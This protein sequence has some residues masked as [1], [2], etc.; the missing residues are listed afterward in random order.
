MRKSLSILC[1]QLFVAGAVVSDVETGH[2]IQ[3]KKKKDLLLVMPGACLHG[4][5]KLSWGRGQNALISSC[6]GIAWVIN[7][8]V[9]IR[10][11]RYHC[12]LTVRAAWVLQLLGYQHCLDIN[13]G[14]LSN[15]VLSW[16]PRKTTGAVITPSSIFNLTFIPLFFLLSFLFFF[17]SSP[18][19]SR[20][21]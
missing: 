13:S 11:P 18:L 17:L 1:R 21:P 19:P 3:K 7:I 4:D 2:H 5:S 12:C 10:R 15:L 20:L 6:A 9:S 16:S 14:F 8:S